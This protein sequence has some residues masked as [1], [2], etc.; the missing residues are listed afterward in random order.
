MKP[1]PK[2]A[3]VDTILPADLVP[4]L[5]FEKEKPEDRAIPRGQSVQGPANALFLL[6]GDQLILGVRVVT[7]CVIT[8][9]NR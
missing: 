9:W 6:F 3:V 4:F 5:F 2:M 1:D 7:W 8:L